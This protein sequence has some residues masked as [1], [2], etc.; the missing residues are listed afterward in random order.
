MSHHRYDPR[1]CR[2]FTEK[3][4]RIGRGVIDNG[5]ESDSWLRKDDFDRHWLAL[6]HFSR[7]Q[8]VNRP[9]SKSP[10]GNHSCFQTADTAVQPSVQPKMCRDV[11]FGSRHDSDTRAV[12]GIME[13]PRHCELAG[14]VLNIRRKAR[15]EV[16]ESSC[17]ICSRDH[18]GRFCSVS[19]HLDLQWAFP[20]FAAEEI[21]HHVL[22]QQS[23]VRFQGARL[24]EFLPLVW[25]VIK[26]QSLGDRIAV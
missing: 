3:H 16:S 11:P 9:L 13:K 25:R 23:R 1:S 10:R 7:K 4:C 15:S 19:Q 2:P 6:S 21:L 18:R 24:C 5:S 8:F 17:R 22:E 20:I 26:P 14:G 12:V